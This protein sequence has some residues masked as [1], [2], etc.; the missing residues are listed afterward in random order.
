MLP[1]LLYQRE[2][3]STVINFYAVRHWHNC[4]GCIDWNSCI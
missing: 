3:N 2:A 1:D 4:E